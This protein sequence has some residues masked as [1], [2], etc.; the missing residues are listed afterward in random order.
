MKIEVLYF[1][2]CPHHEDTL[3]AVRRIA[4]EA[5]VDADVRPVRV[6]D[7][8]QAERLRFLGSPT[9]RI[10]GHDLES[11]AEE[12]T[13]FVLACRVYATEAGPQGRPPDELIRAAIS[14]A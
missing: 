11:G 8:G 10:D 2:G 14:A 9:V 6:G 3:A 7:Q 4:S 5:R 13:D 12:R 1:D